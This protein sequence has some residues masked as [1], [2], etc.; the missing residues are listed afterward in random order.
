MEEEQR[1]SCINAS[2]VVPLLAVYRIEPREGEEKRESAQ[3]DETNG[4]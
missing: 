1:H 4:E 2:D 3:D